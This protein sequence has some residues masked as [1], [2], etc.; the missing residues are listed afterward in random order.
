MSDGYFQL[1]ID[2]E[3]EKQLAELAKAED[4][5]L[6]AQVRILI[7]QEYERKLGQSQAQPTAN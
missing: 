7:R 3:T 1:R 2:P 5:S 6:S 4:R